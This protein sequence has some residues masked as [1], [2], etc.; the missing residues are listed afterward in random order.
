MHPS[1][2]TMI[3]TGTTNR[4]VRHCTSN[5]IASATARY[6]AGFMSSSVREVAVDERRDAAGHAAHRARDA[7]D[8]AQRAWRHELERDDG[9]DRRDPEHRR[10][11]DADLLR[12][13]ACR[14][15][16]ALMERALR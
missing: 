11:D 1:T 14:T 15:T 9:T 8:G 16:E 7:G 5:T 12:V 4:R 3:H 13:D 10:A 6:A 2:V